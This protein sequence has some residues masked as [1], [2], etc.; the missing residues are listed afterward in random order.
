MRRFVAK[1]AGS[2]LGVGYIPFAPGTFGSLVAAL[3]YFVFPAIAP[4]QWLVPLIVV[5]SVLGVWA[6]G[7]MEEEYG[8]DPS[9][10]VIDELAGQ[11]LALAALP[12]TP[13]VVLLSFL[14]FRFY[15]IVK[16]GLVDK[17]QSLPGGWGIMVDDLLAGLLANVTVR[18][19]MLALPFLSPGFNPG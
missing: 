4:L 10:V 8:E 17:A 2:V 14:L 11:W 13:V 18:I 9:A 12:A 5:T 19:V 1:A 6:G 7:V 15:D 16:P 3:A